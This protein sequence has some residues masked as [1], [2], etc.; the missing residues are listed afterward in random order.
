MNRFLAQKQKFLICFSL[1]FIISLFGVLLIAG[2]AQAEGGWF[3]VEQGLI[4][5]LAKFLSAIIGLLGTIVVWV[6]GLAKGVIET[7]N[8]QNA[9]LVKDGWAIVRDVTNMFFI[10]IL[11]II[12]FAT[13]LR[14]ESYGMKALLPKLVGVALLINFSLVLAGA[15]IDFANGLTN[16]FLQDGKLFEEYIPQ[17]LN[18]P[19]YIG[20]TAEGELESKEV[21]HCY[22]EKNWWFDIS[23][24]ALSQDACEAAHSNCVGNCQPLTLNQEQAE[25]AAE[26]LGNIDYTYNMVMA[27][28]LSIVFMMIAIFVLSAL[29]LMF[30]YRILV[31]WFLLILMPIV[32]LL[33]VLPATANMF[34]KWMNKF[35]KWTFFGPICTFFVWLSITSWI[36]FLQGSGSSPAGGASFEMS[37]IAE[38]GMLAQQT[39]PN[40]FLPENLVQFILVCG[41]LIGSLVAAQSLSIHGATGAIGLGKKWGKT[42]AGY[43]LRFAKGTAKAGGRATG[44]AALRTGAP[45]KAISWLQEQTRRVPGVRRGLRPAR[46][47][48]E[49]RKGQ[50]NEAK[51]KYENWSND[52]IYG[53]HKTG[54]TYEKIAMAQILAQRGKLKAKP[55]LGFKEEDIRK[56]TK[57]AY[58][59]GA[60]KDILKARPELAGGLAKKMGKTKQ[61][62]ISDVISG[63]KPADVKSLDPGSLTSEVKESVLKQFQAGGKWSKEHLNEAAKYDVQVHNTI[64]NE[65]L[66]PNYESLRDDIKK[67]LGEAQTTKKEEAAPNNGNVVDLKNEI[68]TVSPVGFGGRKISD[69]EIKES[70]EA[71]KNTNK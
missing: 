21:W 36:R 49:T 54:N 22:V 25:T 70:Q 40:M 63:F 60:E 24:Y 4:N 7:G 42:A 2:N 23:E 45:E 43:P 13:I 57:Y 3:D 28:F 16:S 18:L 47:Y 30:F 12:A 48:L 5:F 67:Y 11:L 29:A 62:A 38:Y 46:D 56:A 55:E 66:Q 9:S 64:Q 39:V 68:E 27:M 71:L 69:E 15:V 26:Q 53:Q 35:F 44:Q 10:L 65:I 50:I 52:H 37:E 41:M 17:A 51:K 19:G 33:W 14:R 31:L 58:N 8:L 34:G 61:E 20:T 6:V 59:L 1:I 32:L